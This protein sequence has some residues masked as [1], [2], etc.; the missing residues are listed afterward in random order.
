MSLFFIFRVVFFVAAT[1]LQYLHDSNIGLGC[2]RMQFPVLE[3]F[4]DL[5]STPAVRLMWGLLALHY[6]VYAILIYLVF[7]FYDL[8]A[9]N[10][11][12]CVS[13]EHVMDNYGDGMMRSWVQNLDKTAEFGKK[14]DI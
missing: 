7:Y 9:A 1:I 10:E 8:E 4:R 11:G 6:V 14:E 5:D 3:A 12:Q 13:G 2:M